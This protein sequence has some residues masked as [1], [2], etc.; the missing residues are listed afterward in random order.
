MEAGVKPRIWHGSDL[1][2][3][4][5]GPLDLGLGYLLALPI[6]QPPGIV[7]IHH[8]LECD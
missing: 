6:L 2:D 4:A 5:D 3:S 1:E 7:L 8:V